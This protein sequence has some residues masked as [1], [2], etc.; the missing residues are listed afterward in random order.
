MRKITASFSLFD[1]EGIHLNTLAEG[2][3]T[4]P[5]VECAAFYPG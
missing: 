4:Q 3:V 2:I 5:R 1:P